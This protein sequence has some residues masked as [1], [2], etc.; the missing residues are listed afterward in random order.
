MLMLCRGSY[1]DGKL[2][3][4]V[5]PCAGN[6]GTQITVRIIR[7]IDHNNDDKTKLIQQRQRHWLGRI[8]S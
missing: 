4:P 8:L 2:K 1:C 7:I 6:V 3:E 5:K